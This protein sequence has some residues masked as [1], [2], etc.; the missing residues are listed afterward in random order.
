[1]EGI[2]L[3]AD[4]AAVNVNFWITNDSA[5]LDSESGGLDIYEHKAPK[6]WGFNMY[7]MDSE[8]IMEYLDSVYSTSIIVPYK[9]NRSVIF[10]SDL[11]HRTDNFYFK[12]GYED[13]RIN[14]TMLFGTR[15]IQQ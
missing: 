13:R 4:S 6:D 5:N 3:H 10:D 8:V 1:M 2:N 14:I 11:F 7:N 9:R 12:D 15:N